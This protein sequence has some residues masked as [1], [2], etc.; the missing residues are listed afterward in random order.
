MLT[1]LMALPAM[2]QTPVTGGSSSEEPIGN[3]TM[4]ALLQRGFEIKASSPSGNKFV[5]FL[6]K[7]AQAYACEF[8][9]LTNSRCGAIDQ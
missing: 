2:A 5:V 7:D 8:V 3:A 9:T 4:G 1:L 6:Q